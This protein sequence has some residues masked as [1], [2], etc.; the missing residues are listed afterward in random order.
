YIEWPRTQPAFTDAV[1]RCLRGQLGGRRRDLVAV[2]R[3]R[4]PRQPQ[5]VPRVARDHVDVEV[6]D[7]LPG[8]LPARVEQVHAVCMQTFLRARGHQLRG[9]RAGLEILVRDLQQVG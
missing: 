6:E 1:W 2:A 8:R 7:G 4:V 3:R 9:A 5:R